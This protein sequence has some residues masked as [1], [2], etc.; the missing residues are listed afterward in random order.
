V[1]DHDVRRP[2][3]TSVPVTL[4]RPLQIAHF[5][6]QAPKLDKRIQ[7]RRFDLNSKLISLE[8]LNEITSHLVARA[9]KV[10]IASDQVA[11]RERNRGFVLIDCRLELPPIEVHI[12]E[13]LLP[14]MLRHLRAIFGKTKAFIEAAFGKEL[15]GAVTHLFMGVK[16]THGVTLW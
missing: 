2:N 10:L 8:R 14:H 16:L 5:D 6:K 7:E 15:G 4:R 11:W 9:D 12:A 3:D 13:T 1:G